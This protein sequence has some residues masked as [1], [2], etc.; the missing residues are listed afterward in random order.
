MNYGSVYEYGKIGHINNVA[1]KA[2]FRR[3]YLILSQH[4]S[5]L[6]DHLLILF[7]LSIFLAEIHNAQFELS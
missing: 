4:F 2:I 1:G 3:T 5:G 6:I 7:E